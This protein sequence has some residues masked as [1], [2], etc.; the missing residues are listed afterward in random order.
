MEI[1]AVDILATVKDADIEPSKNSLFLFSSDTGKFS[2]DE[3]RID[4]AYLES[5]T[6][7]LSTDN[8]YQNR[9]SVRLMDKRFK[10]RYLKISYPYSES[11]SP[12]YLF[13]VMVL[14]K[15]KK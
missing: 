2:G 1:D 13:E 3:K 15:E 10:A 14:V 11:T 7:H 9:K 8:P 4:T 12:I 5:R 6:A